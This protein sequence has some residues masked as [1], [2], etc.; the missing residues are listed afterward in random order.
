M[1][2]CQHE[3]CIIYTYKIS[4]VLKH[5]DNQSS[6]KFHICLLSYLFQD[7]DE[8]T[9]TYPTIYELMYDLKGKLYLVFHVWVFVVVVFWGGLGKR[10]V[11]GYYVQFVFFW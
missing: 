6:L 2:A 4:Y 8:V 5:N 9:I 7:I 11:K 3:I 10:K 1:S